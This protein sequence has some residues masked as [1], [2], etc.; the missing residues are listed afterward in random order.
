M[1]K[2]FPNKNSPTEEEIKDWITEK[3]GPVK[4]VVFARNFGAIIRDY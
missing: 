2:G 1:L 3:I 4:E